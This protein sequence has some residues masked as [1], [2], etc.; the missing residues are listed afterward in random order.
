MEKYIQL[1]RGNE[2]EGRSAGGQIYF[3]T[4][5]NFLDH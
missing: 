4:I 1:N 2:K 3:V 5:G